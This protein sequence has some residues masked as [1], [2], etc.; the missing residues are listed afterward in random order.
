MAV[1]FGVLLCVVGALG[2]NVHIPS[3]VVY[4]G[5]ADSMFGFTV[6]AHVDNGQKMI[7]VGAPEADSQ[8]LSSNRKPGAVYRCDAGERG[9]QRDTPL[10]HCQE[11][12]FDK[13]RGNTRDKQQNPIDEKSNQWFGA[14]LS[15]TGKN[16]PIVACAPR[17]VSFVNHRLQHRDP[18]GACFVASSSDGHDVKEFSPCRT[19]SHGN[20]K[21]GVCQAGFSAAI[22]KDVNGFERLFM[23]A[24]GSWY[25]QGQIYSQ[26]VGSNP[27][28][29]AT[30][31]ANPKYDDSYMG[32]SVA[33]GDF[34]GTKQQ[35]VAVG[36]PRG[37][38][39]KG[40]VVLY[41]WDLQNIRNISGSQIGA[42]F[43]YSLASGDIDGDGLDDVIVGSPMFSKPKSDGFEH[44]RIY[45]IYQGRD[46]SFL[47]SHWI[48]GEVSR[49]RFGLS[50]A[51]LGDINYDG[52]GDIAVGAPYGGEH[53]RG[54][55]Y[56]FQGS[57]TG[58]RDK[59]S[60]AIKAEDISPSL[61]TFGFSLSGGVDLDD[62]SYNDL[63]VGAYKSDSVV[64]L[65][66]QP[67]VKVMAEVKFQEDTKLISLTDKR[68]TTRDGTKAV[69]S[70]LIYCLQFGGINVDRQI[71]FNVSLD[72][73]SRKT[74]TKRILT[75][76]RESTYTT[77]I[78]LEQ[79]QQK[80]DSLT[81]YL[82][83]EIRDKLT[84][85]EVKMTYNLMN[86]EPH[87][88]IVPPVLDQTQNIQ[89]ADSLNIQKNCGP[90]N[91]C[92]PNLH[93]EVSSPIREYTLGSGENINLDVTV[94]NSGEDAFEAAYYLK[95]PAGVTFA[96]M[97]RLDKDSEASQANIYCSVI[98]GKDVSLNTTLKCDLGNPM[99]RDEKVHFQVVLEVDTTV[100]SMVFDMETNSTNP[101]Q[102][103]NY[104]NVRRLSI[105]VLVKAMLSVI[106]TSDPPELHYNASLYELENFTDEAKLG[107]QV[108]HKYQIKNE[109]PFTADETEFYIMWPYQT[110]TE[111]NLMYMLVQPQPLGNVRCDVARNVNPAN[112]VVSSPYVSWLNKEKE[113]MESSEF[114]SIY[115]EY[116]AQNSRDWYEQRYYSGSEAGQFIGEG[117]RQYGQSG[118]SYYQSGGGY[119]QSGGSVSQSGSGYRQNG[120]SV[121]TYDR[122]SIIAQEE[123]RKRM[124]AEAV[125]REQFNSLFGG[126]F[127]YN[128][129]RDEIPKDYTVT[130][131]R[132]K[133]V[134]YD[135]RNNI[136]WQAETST[137]YGGLIGQE[138]GGSYHASGQDY[139]GQQGSRGVVSHSGSQGSFQGGAPF[140]HRD[141]ATTETVNRDVINRDSATYRAGLTSV[142]DSEDDI[143]G[144]G[145]SAAQGTNGEF[146]SGV[147]GVGYDNRQSA[148]QGS[149]SS[150][151]RSGYQG[152]YSQGYQGQGYQ[153][154]QFSSG[155]QS[156]RSGGAYS[157]SSH[158][159]S[160][161]SAQSGGSYSSGQKHES[162]RRKR[163]DQFQVDSQLSA[164]LK[165]CNEKYKCAVVHCATGRLLKGQEVWVAL[166]TRLN[167]SVL[168]EISKDRPVKISSLV[169]AHVTQLPIVGSPKHT[170]WHQ[171]EAKTVVT[172]QLGAAESGSIPL[173]VI[174]LAAVVGALL[175]LLLIFALYKCGFFKRNRPS[176][177]NERQP[178]NGRDEHL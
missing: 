124:E 125:A 174:I 171:A 45:V 88:G 59:Y 25:W 114:A 26:S 3:R 146:R 127:D 27:I 76:R 145:A 99:S 117:G 105:G 19:P 149:Q 81:V 107:P 165:S 108:I 53:G 10:D 12:W 34:A 160:G 147:T 172:P 8:Y 173:W 20:R 73:D 82:D 130:K 54:V 23:G 37:A 111:E 57:E 104:D 87:G 14:T 40:L 69:C 51:S 72:L 106:G 1:Y 42:Y 46:R 170:T 4:K 158:S 120:G 169:A 83:E 142:G 143:G 126:K 30:P 132:N 5:S 67:V 115:R 162:A 101:E 139:F 86:Q 98:G 33:V 89:A 41:T 168:N 47:K 58:I 18:V 103:T 154:G 65:K 11:M 109:G 77:T 122:N 136:V 64:F 55:V 128:R 150:G 38:G 75:E 137:E 118:G 144:F 80:C 116:I 155:S 135:D 131:Y 39:L 141:F 92:I 21:T 96:K 113:A 60:Q 78:A 22:S 13:K 110:L 44:G 157:Y 56:I 52:F 35:G 71:K 129:N 153:G 84:P 85:I 159:E 133:T 24:P 48:T 167:A 175:L 102:N 61:T 156:A 15:S 7:L 138:A 43:G 49:G 6:Q 164:L 152:G 70:K 176:D 93:M 68:C 123:T 91:V 121:N 177:H 16:G 66:S 29:I 90:D 100:S 140:V 2:F 31:E 119:R 79:G 62:N 151:G 63:A 161:Y 134:V 9:Y 163:E 94:T 28:L 50:V 74:T 112:L 95:I 17:Y 32:Y 166:R 97:E 148:S 36:M 178:L